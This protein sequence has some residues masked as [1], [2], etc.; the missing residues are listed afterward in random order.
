MNIFAHEAILKEL[1]TLK[2]AAAAMYIY[3]FLVIY[4]YPSP[5]NMFIK[6]YMKPSKVLKI[7]IKGN[8]K[9]QEILLIFVIRLKNE[10]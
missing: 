4:S 10:F 3:V 7:C 2:T 8:G 5:K 1:P 6:V 9:L